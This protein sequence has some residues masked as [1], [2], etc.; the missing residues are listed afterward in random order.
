MMSTLPR[1]TKYMRV[2]RAIINAQFGNT[3]S[4]RLDVAQKSR[5]QAEQTLGD[6]FHCLAIRQG[7]EP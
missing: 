2:A 3:L 7:F 1:W 5:L 6:P 4:N